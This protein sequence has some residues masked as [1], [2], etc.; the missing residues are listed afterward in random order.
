MFGDETDVRMRQMILWWLAGTRS[1]KEDAGCH[2]SGHL[3]LLSKQHLH[4]G[5]GLQTWPQGKGPCLPL[6][7]GAQASVPQVGGRANVICRSFVP[8]FSR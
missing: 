1:R 4:F 3:V 2:T 5:L 8:F 7:G 6:S